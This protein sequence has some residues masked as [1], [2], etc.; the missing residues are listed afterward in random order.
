M[1][2][3]H[4][5]GL[6]CSVFSVQCSVFSHLFS[7]HESQVTLEGLCS[8]CILCSVCSVLQLSFEGEN[9]RSAEDE[10]LRGF[11]CAQLE[12]PTVKQGDVV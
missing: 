10:K 1:P 2:V 12:A 9:E 3:G 11:R 8:V 4:Q 5:G 7:I 6:F